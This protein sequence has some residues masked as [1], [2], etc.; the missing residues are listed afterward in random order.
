MS[1]KTDIAE[2]LFDFRVAKAQKDAEGGNERVFICDEC[3]STLAVSKDV[4]VAI[5]PVC[6]KTIMF[7]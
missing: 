5:C 3:A 6:N 4:K 7:V 1:N 2:V